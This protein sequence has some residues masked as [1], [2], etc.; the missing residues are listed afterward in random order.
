MPFESDLD[1]M[2]LA[3]HPSE[4]AHFVT[5]VGGDAPR[6][7]IGACTIRMGAVGVGIAAS[8][9]G[10]IEQLLTERPRAVVLVGTCGAYPG[11]G[12]AIADVL[13][14]RGTRLVSTAAARG[15]GYMPEPMLARFEASLEIARAL[16]EAASAPPVEVATTLA[17]TSDEEL[18]RTLAARTGCVAEHLETYGVALACERLGVRWGAVLGVANQVGPRAHEEWLSHHVRASARACQLVLHWIERGAPG[19]SIGDER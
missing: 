12:R 6:I 19:L 14:A 16:G 13:V 15:H 7:G 11:S 1:V 2:V 4:L 8:A 17:I 18:A 10:A 3:A 9:A 5:S